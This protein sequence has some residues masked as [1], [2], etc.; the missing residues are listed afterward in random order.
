[1]KWDAFVENLTGKTLKNSEVAILTVTPLPPKQN[2]LRQ[3]RPCISPHR[4]ADCSHLQT[5]T[6]PQD[7]P[8]CG[9]QSNSSN[10]LIFITP[11]LH[12]YW[13]NSTA[14][15]VVQH[16]NGSVKRQRKIECWHSYY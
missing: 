7:E 14:E 12:S 5:T 2:K 6:A 10:V 11:R 1:M 9:R 4:G 15:I 8:Q 3:G 13:R 16:Y